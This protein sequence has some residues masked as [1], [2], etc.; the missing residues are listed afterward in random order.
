MKKKQSMRPWMVHENQN[1]KRKEVIYSMKKRQCTKSWMYAVWIVVSALTLAILPIQ[2]QA[3]DA[4]LDG[5]VETGNIILYG[6]ATYPL[7]GQGMDRLSCL[8]PAT[9]DLFVI[10]IPA[11]TSNIP[12]NPL[13]YIYMPKSVGG[14]AIATH[15]IAEGQTDPSRVVS[16]SS[17]QKA[18]RITESLDTSNLNILGSASY[19][20]PNGLDNA[21]VYT[22]RI[23]EFIKSKCGTNY[24]TNTNCLDNTGNYGQ[25]VVNKY[26]KHTIA[27]EAGHMMKLTKVYDSKNGGNH[28]KTGT[29]VIMDQSVY[30]TSKSGKVTFYMGTTFTSNDQTDATL[31]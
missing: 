7:C 19:G 31:K 12:G 21:T 20:T 16:P 6:G 24:A 4:D 14:L 22:Q 29:N 3:Q 23:I 30:Y 1:Y 25:A 8:D 28:Y 17:S 2:T 11:G 5:F 18:I 9:K 26:I 15:Q 10:L 27:H 13:E